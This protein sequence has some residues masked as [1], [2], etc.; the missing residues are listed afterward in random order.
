M[1]PAPIRIRPSLV[2]E[3]SWVLWRM[4]RSHALGN[5]SLLSTVAAPKPLIRLVGELWSDGFEGFTELAVMAHQAGSMFARDLGSVIASVGNA[6]AP[7][8]SEGSRRNCL[9]NA[10]R[11]FSELISLL[12][13]RVCARGIRTC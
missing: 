2:L 5:S 4:E 11:S 1:T 13:I 10:S 8:N 6:S 9:T 7:A 12:A 3:L